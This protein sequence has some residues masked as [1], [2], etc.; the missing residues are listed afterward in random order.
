[1]LFLCCWF[2]SSAF[3]CALVSLWLPSEFG[4]MAV[5]GLI[6]SLSQLVLVHHCLGHHTSAS[7]MHCWEQ[8][9]S[10]Y[11]LDGLTLPQHYTLNICQACGRC[12]VRSVSGTDI[13]VNGVTFSS[14]SVHF[15]HGAVD[16]STSSAAVALCHLC[17]RNVF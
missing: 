5:F 10:R 4:L 13:T 12:S 2:Y 9:P 15:C 8:A 3:C 16:S 6:A 1:M 17:K 14:N 11:S 7:T